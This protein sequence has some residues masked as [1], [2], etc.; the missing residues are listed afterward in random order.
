MWMSPLTYLSS[1]LCHIH[2]ALPYPWTS[3]MRLAFPV[4]HLRLP[5]AINQCYDLDKSPRSRSK[6]A[7]RLLKMQM[8]TCNWEL[9]T[10][11][12][13]PTNRLG[14]WDKLTVLSIW[15]LDFLPQYV[16][17]ITGK[18]EYLMSERQCERPRKC[19][20][21][22]G[23]RV[24]ASVLAETDMHEDI[25]LPGPT[26]LTRTQNRPVLWHIRTSK[27]DVTKDTGVYFFFHPSDENLDLLMIPFQVSAPVLLWH[28]RWPHVHD[29]FLQLP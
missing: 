26:C 24:C 28:F 15:P 4:S 10:C 18:H 14:S 5:Q 6:A 29:H 7:L 13:Q 1:L 19:S 2:M 16:I 21:A 9:G 12:N 20:D 25:S 23:K 11:K 27:I 17:H 3:I 22:T 8:G